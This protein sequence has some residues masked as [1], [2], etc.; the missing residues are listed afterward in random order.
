MNRI[1]G[2]FRFCGRRIEDEEIKLMISAYNNSC[3]YHSILWSEGKFGLG[4]YTSR[5]IENNK[6]EYFKRYVVV[7]DAR[8]D[9]KKELLSKLKL[10]NINVDSIPEGELILYSYLNWGE[11]CPCYLIGDYSFAIL[12]KQ[13]ELIFCARDHIGVRPFYYTIN[14]EEFIFAS[15]AKSLIKI[16]GSLKEL[17][18]VRIADY[19]MQFHQDE[20]IT[21]YKNIVRL[22]PGHSIT[23]KG[24]VANISRYWSLSD[25]VQIGELPEN[26]YAD[27][28]RDIFTNSVR[29][30]VVKNSNTSCMLSGGFDSSVITLIAVDCKKYNSG[31]PVN[32]FSLIFD[33]VHQSDE[34][35][36]IRAIVDM[37]GINPVYVA[38]DKI[39]PFLSMKTMIEQIDEPFYT[40]NLYLFW[41]LYSVAS[42]LSVESILDGFLG[43][44]VVGHGSRYITELAS[45][46]RV[47]QLVNEMNSIAKL[48]G[49]D[50]WSTYKYLLKDFVWLP[51]FK[52]QISRLWS[53]N[54]D[55]YLAES[56]NAKLINKDFLEDI[57][58]VKRAGQYGYF[59]PELTLTVKKEQY[60]DLSS[61]YISGVLEVF[62]KLGSAHG[63]VPSFPF[64]DINLVEYCL[65]VP[66]NQKYNSGVTRYY[67]RNAMR[68]YLPKILQNRYDKKY[69][70][71]NIYHCMYSNSIK[72]MEEYVYEKVPRAHEY[73]NVAEIQ[74][75]HERIKE[76]F[77]K[78]QVIYDAGRINLIWSTI[79]LA[80]WL[81]S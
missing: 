38:G 68:N 50:K 29:N 64:T 14:N 71:Y 15:E 53:K 3:N 49:K 57:G 61:G 75:L 27:R 58:W 43:D 65:A 77:R 23:V 66:A 48:S 46:F 19:L 41:E 70:H 28:F 79:A 10:G 22:P 45:K 20:S 9:N 26:D 72:Q 56:P 51:L 13:S 25:K 34:Q 1:S 8:I 47:F 40:P 11:N 80:S 35:E 74:S 42:N 39:D 54:I 78:N 16:I 37:G 52:N 7:S 69:L 32:T 24:G 5:N 60:D 76:E 81:D 59:T 30:R 73:L 33:D 21:F 44:N 4:K 55:S 36:Y 31:E 17:N 2:I 62:S 6:L 63:I 12:D 18:H 67:A